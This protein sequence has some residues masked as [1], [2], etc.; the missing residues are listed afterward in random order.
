MLFTIFDLGIGV[1]GRG[2]FFFDAF[3]L[4]KE[5]SGFFFSFLVLF[6]HA[7]FEFKHDLIVL[8]IIFKF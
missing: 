3:S 6:P 8:L 2:E 1:F 5:L 7:L 4:I